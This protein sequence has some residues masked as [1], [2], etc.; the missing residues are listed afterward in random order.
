MNGNVINNRLD[1]EHLNFK[2][3]KFIIWKIEYKKEN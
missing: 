1:Y 2:N 3:F